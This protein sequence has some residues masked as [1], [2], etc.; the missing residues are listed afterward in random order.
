MNKLPLA[1]LHAPV[2]D[3]HLDDSW[4]IEFRGPREVALALRDNL[5][6]GG[7]HPQL[8]MCPYNGQVSV[9][10][11]VHAPAQELSQRVLNHFQDF[12]LIEHLQDGS[13]WLSD[14]DGGRLWVSLSEYQDIR[15]DVEFFWGVQ[16][17]TDAA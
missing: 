8:A 11:S 10:M 16:R 3:E 5:R 13:V 1:I 9:S 4:L 17:W 12:F 15:E 7:F 14:A 6:A 2:P